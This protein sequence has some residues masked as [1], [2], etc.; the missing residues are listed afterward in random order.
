MTVREEHPLSLF[1]REFDE[2]FDRFFSRLPTLF[3]D[4]GIGWGLETDET[5]KEYLVRIDAPGFE[6]ED[7]NVE[8][9][10]GSLRISA[11]HKAEGNGKGTYAH[12]RLERYVTLPVGVDPDKVEAGYRNGVLELRLPK[13]ER[14]QWKRIAVKAS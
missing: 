10:E 12:R 4:R 8:V 11:E 14:A 13:T 6:P 3:E 9:C 7:I 1:H 2:M 5:D